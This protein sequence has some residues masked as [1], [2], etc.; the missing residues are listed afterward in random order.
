MKKITRTTTT[1]TATTMIRNAMSPSRL[2]A[3]FLLAAACSSGAAN[4]PAAPG[5][6]GAGG[7]S[8]SQPGQVAPSVVLPATEE[9]AVS[10]AAWFQV[11]SS[12]DPSGK[13]GLAWLTAQ[14]V[15]RA[16]TQA[17]KYDQILALLYPMAA[18][19]QISV[20]TEMTVFSGRA[21]R[22]Q[23][24]TYLPLFVAAYTKP[25]FDQADFER[26]KAEAT[27]YVEKSLRYALDEE[28]GKAAFVGALFAGTGY[29]HPPQGTAASLRAITLDD[30][31][32][33]WRE[34]YTRDRVVFGLAGGWSDSLR[35]GLEGS[36]AALAASAP[37]P[38]AEAPTVTPPS[39]RQ[40]VLVD[41]PGADASISFGFPISVRRGHP[42]FAALYLVTSW[43]GEHR[44]SSSHLYH[45]IRSTRGLNYGDYAYV[46]AYPNGG[47]R[48]TPPP[49]VSRRQQAYEIWIRT[50]PNKNA[51]FALRAALRELDR[52][53]QNGLTAE[54]VELTRSFLSKYLLHAAPATHDRLL[55]SFD[56][57]FYGLSAPHLDKLREEI[58]ALTLEQVNAAIKRHLSADNL[59]IAIATGEAAQ[60]RE[61]LTSGAPTKP[62]YDSPK[63]KPILAED[64][65][66]AS[67]PLNIASR[68]I[69]VVPVDDM[70]AKGR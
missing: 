60:I 22:E 5:A 6:P 10:M 20:D 19:Y 61:Q 16:A 26:L 51:V 31:R 27:S 4:K 38:R 36:R 65:E 52:L 7:T 12:D 66:I 13:E 3:C 8:P 49:N 35:S 59:V 56:D 9:P 34:H 18:Q 53:A 17:H 67:Y 55:W 15:A 28:L 23:A 1:N 50:V 46:E 58:K 29:A 70:F 68:S 44:N 39:G 41:K 25:A 40:V 30:V 63:P 24:A 62:T 21:P 47:R 32:A 57:R 43:L 45:V 33:F 48:Q 64:E 42:D 69:K 14:M 54:Q 37:S 11:G 2:L